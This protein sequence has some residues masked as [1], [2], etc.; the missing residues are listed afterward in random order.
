MD[1]KISEL[2]ELYHNTKDE[3]YFEQ[4]LERFQPL[5]RKYAKKLYYIETE[6]SI[7]ELNLAIYKAVKSMSY[8]DNEYACISYLNKIVYHRFCKL[9]AAS[10][11]LQNK[12]E[13]EVPYD[14]FTAGL[15]DSSIKDKLFLLD[16][17]ALL[18]SLEYPKKDILSMILEGYSDKEIGQKLHCSRQYI[19][20]IKK[21][22]LSDNGILLSPDKKTSGDA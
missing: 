5:V 21:T 3:G 4:I 2:I 17:H 14:D 15:E 8:I 7:Q 18:D 1:N 9:Y 11:S 13:R 20:R 6:D 10:S 22:L 19:N 16:L 12:Q